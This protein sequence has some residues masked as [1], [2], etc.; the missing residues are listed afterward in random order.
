MADRRSAARHDDDD[1]DTASTAPSAHG[2]EVHGAR[3]SPPAGRTVPCATS[4]EL[5]QRKK[6]Y[7]KLMSLV[8]V[9]TVTGVPRREPRPPKGRAVSLERTDRQL[10]ALSVDPW[11]PMVSLRVM[12]GRQREGLA[13]CAGESDAWAW[14][15]ANANAFWWVGWIEGGLQPQKRV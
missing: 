9:C 13:R 10:A 7:G 1:D 12:A 8:E 4:R 6:T 2:L 5:G 15:N 3:S 14:A 11:R